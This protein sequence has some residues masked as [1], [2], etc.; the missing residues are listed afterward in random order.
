MSQQAKQQHEQ[1]RDAALGWV[2]RLRSDEVS[3]DDRHAFALWLGEHRSHR[4]AMDEALDLWDDLGV[5]RH[6]QPETFPATKAANSARWLPAALVSAAACLVLAV[7]LWPQL[8]PEPVSTQ[9]S[10]AV[11]ERL[12]VTL[13]DGSLARLNTNSQIS[14]SYSDDERLIELQ[15]GEA[16]F[17]VEPNK[18]KPF[19]VDA[20][21][22]RV[23]AV[24]TAFN[25]Y[26]R[27]ESTEIAV[28]EGVVRV[29]ERQTA[30]GREPASKL[31]RINE[32]LLSQ[33]QGWEV[34]TA[35][36]LEQALA[37]RQ[38]QLVAREM[39]LPQL[40]A[41]LQRYS[42]TRIFISD[43][44]LL[45]RTVS[46]VFELDN[47]E[48]SLEALAISMGLEIRPLSDSAVRLL[49]ADQ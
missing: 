42:D 7:F 20:G 6:L 48:T 23:T 11:G 4:A 14:V 37:W 17:R 30:P 18:D 46:G 34:S 49:K 25:V 28:T 29:T 9:Y 47:P 36:D 27:G 1:A 35:D 41:Q 19:H 3:A 40:V 21:E 13:P 16:W 32:R 24:G 8:Q 2:A 26:R 45:N 44:A 12:D 33:R 38:G 31:L 15:K 5:V 22:A 39:P 10:S 43:P